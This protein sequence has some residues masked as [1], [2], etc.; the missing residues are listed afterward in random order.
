MKIDSNFEQVAEAAKFTIRPMSGRVLKLLVKDAHH[1]QYIDE[2]KI[3]YIDI[4]GLIFKKDDIITVGKGKYKIMHI[5]ND[6]VYGDGY[7]FYTHILTKISFHFIMPSL[8]TFATD[9]RLGAEFCNCFI[10]ME[11]NELFGDSIYLLYAYLVY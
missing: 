3:E 6:G 1:A 9:F 11:G 2:R 8:G 5:A 4:D 10:G 7:T